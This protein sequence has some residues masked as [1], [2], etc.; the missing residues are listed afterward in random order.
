MIYEFDSF[1]SYHSFCEKDP[2]FRGMSPGGAAASMS[3]TRQAV[4]N[5]IRRGSLDLVRITESGTGPYLYI[6][7]RSIRDYSLNR[8]GKKGPR[9]GFRSLIQ[10]Q[11]DKHI[12]NV[13]PNDQS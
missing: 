3:I 6:P 11:I 2:S 4:F 5:A 10:M 1:D 7:E 13:W 8:L 9:P 12:N